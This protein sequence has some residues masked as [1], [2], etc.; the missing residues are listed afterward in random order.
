MTNH[1]DKSGRKPGLGSCYRRGRLC[2]QLKM[3]NDL[4]VG[5]VEKTLEFQVQIIQRNNIKVNT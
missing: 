2:Y 4:I 3:K 1:G 5:Q